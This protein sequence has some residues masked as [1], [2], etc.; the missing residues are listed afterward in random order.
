M[1]GAGNDFV[2]IDLRQQNFTLD[3][4]RAAL[5]ADRKRGIG[6]DQIL[7]LKDARNAENT[8]R[9]EIWNAD[10]SLAG[11]CGNGARCI[12]LYL[13][14]QGKL[15]NSD[16]SLESPSGTIS[17]RISGDG[18][19]EVDMGVPEFESSKVPLT[20]SALN[21]MVQIESPWGILELA[22]VSMGN[23][24]A[25]M[26]CE[27]L[28]DSEI[29]Q[30]G[31]FV[32]AHPG[33]PEGC[34]VG[35]AKILDRGKIQLRVYERGVGETLACGSGACAAVAI[36]KQRGLVDS[37]VDVILTGGHLVIKW[38]GSGQSLHMKGPAKYVFKGKVNG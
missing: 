18:E 22:A 32:S 21:G 27:E 9:Y 4:R 10:G 25:L 29:A 19:F 28:E 31:P 5:I 36:L 30:I 23:P 35:F 12:G 26:L 3:A 17:L 24:H 2:L 34:N 7:V 11:Q 6:C 14:R 33:F 8:A 20:L 13:S 38:P 16:F 1:H 15:V 37:V